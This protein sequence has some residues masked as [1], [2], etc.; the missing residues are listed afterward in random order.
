[1]NVEMLRDNANCGVHPSYLHKK[2]L[3]VGQSH[4]AKKD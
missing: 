3:Q 4:N 1:M 2:A